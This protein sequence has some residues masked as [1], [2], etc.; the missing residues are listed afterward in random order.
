MMK[1]VLRASSKNQSTSTRS[2]SK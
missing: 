1:Q 2:Q